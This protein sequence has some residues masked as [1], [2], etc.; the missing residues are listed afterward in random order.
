[1]QVDT[2]VRAASV[3]R[4]LQACHTPLEREIRLAKQ[5]R[6]LTAVRDLVQ[7]GE[8]GE[9]T[10]AALGDELRHVAQHADDI[11]RATA[12]HVRRL[13]RMTSTVIDAY[14]D[15]NRLR[16]TSTRVRAAQLADLLDRYDFDAVLR[17]FHT[18]E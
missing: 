8:P 14:V 17:F 5:A 15:M 2:A 16:G 3:N 13:E 6:L 4:L 10:M 7:S 11:T 9:Q 12:G 18:G 1:V